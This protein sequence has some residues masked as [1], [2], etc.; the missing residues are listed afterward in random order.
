MTAR[1]WLHAAR[2]SSP[3][4]QEIKAFYMRLNDDG[5]TVAAMDVLVPKVGELVGGSQREDR[6]D[7][8]TQRITGAPARAAAPNATPELAPEGRRAGGLALRGLRMLRRSLLLHRAHPAALPL[9]PA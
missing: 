4:P 7:V 5:K 8:L 1:P 2:A 6:L 9:P 3:P